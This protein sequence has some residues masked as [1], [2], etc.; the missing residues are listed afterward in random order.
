[1]LAQ[2][3]GRQVKELG[4]ANDMLDRIQVLLHKVIMLHYLPLLR[5]VIIT[6]LHYLPLLRKVI[7]VLYNYFQGDEYF[8]PIHALVP[9]IINPSNFI[10]RAPQQ[11]SNSYQ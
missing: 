6:C 3:A 9:D 10:G 2:E 1:M 11:V 5:K 7:I 8:A 4:K